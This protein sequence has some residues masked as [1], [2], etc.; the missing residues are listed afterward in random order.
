MLA[1]RQKEMVRSVW[2]LVHTGSI[3]APLWDLMAAGLHSLDMGLAHARLVSAGSAL[4]QVLCAEASSEPMWTVWSLGRPW[5]RAP[6][7]ATE[8]LLL[9]AS[10]AVCFWEGWALCSALTQESPGARG[11]ESS[12]FMWRMVFG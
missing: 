4:V 5:P 3:S 12:V 1:P 7:M 6:G 8:A 9:R 10:C 2:L 11:V